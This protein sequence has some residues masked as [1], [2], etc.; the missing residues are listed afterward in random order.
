[1]KY[2]LLVAAFLLSA[3]ASQPVHESPASAELPTRI[4]HSGPDIED[5]T[6]PVSIRDLVA[7]V[8]KVTDHDA[9]I[10]AGASDGVAVGDVYLL[11]ENHENVGWIAVVEC[12]ERQAL[13]V[14]VRESLLPERPGQVAVK[15]LGTW[16]APEQTTSGYGATSTA[17]MP[18]GDHPLGPWT[19]PSDERVTFEA[20]WPVLCCVVEIGGRAHHIARAARLLWGEWRPGT[21]VVRRRGAKSGEAVL[22]QDAAGGLYAYPTAE[23]KPEFA[24]WP[25][26]TQLLGY[27]YDFDMKA[28]DESKQIDYEAYMRLKRGDSST[29]KKPSI[30][31]PTAVVFNVLSARRFELQ[32]FP[33]PIRIGQ[34]VEV[35]GREANLGMATAIRAAD[36][37]IIFQLDRLEGEGFAIERGDRVYTPLWRPDRPLRVAVHGTLTQPPHT[38]TREEL[39]DALVRHGCEVHEQV[40]PKT[41]LAILGANLLRDDHYRQARNSLRLDTL[42]VE[43]AMRYLER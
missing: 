34:R 2:K 19:V 41:D 17:P 35:W 38:L 4:P 20:H 8:V 18:H 28:D 23:V 11:R 42:R 14:P 29:L 31:D 37:S 13:C 15:A 27:T 5:V 9:W 43:E 3:C 10:D 26:G 12:R 21:S 39:I 16:R 22:V 36:G 30:P 32:E 6:E 40:G 24:S 7:N 1:M 33:N 25:D